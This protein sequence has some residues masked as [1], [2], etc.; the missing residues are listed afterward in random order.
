VQLLEKGGVFRLPGSS[1]QPTNRKDTAMS[2]STATPTS[3]TSTFDF[4]PAE[5]GSKI[6]PPVHAIVELVAAF[7]QRSPT[8]VTTN[9][10]END[11]AERLRILGRVVVEWTFNHVEPEEPAAVP[12]TLLWQDVAYRRK[13]KSR[14]RA[15]CCRFGPIRLWRHRYEAVDT[16]EPSIFPLELALG[17]EAERATPA[18][19]ERV[20]HAAAIHTQ[21]GVLELLARYHGVRWSVKTP[22]KVTASLS[23]GMAEH[24][25]AAQAARGVEALRQASQSAGPHPPT[26]SVGRDGVMVPMRGS[27]AYCEAATGTISVLDRQGRRI[28]TTY[29]GRMPEKEQKTLSL[30]M[31]SLLLAALTL[32]KG[33]LPRLQYVTDGGSHPTSY[34]RQVLRKMRHPVTGARLSWEW[35]IDFFHAS[36]Y[37]T[38]LGEALYGTT[39]KGVAWSAKMRHWLRHKPGGIQRVLYSAAAVHARQAL[40]DARERDYQKAWNYLRK[41]KR[42]MDYA[43][44]KARGLAIGSGVTEAACK[45]VFTQ[46]VKQSGMRWGV[47]GGQVIVDLRI[48]VL[49]R[50]WTETHHAYLASKPKME[51]G[52]LW[53]RDVKKTGK[54]A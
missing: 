28:H 39:R 25:E 37:V 48:L 17:I 10:F 41:R 1:K 21:G 42:R 50:V 51:M 54:A 14:N 20:G 26:L 53:A 16:S 52:T 24:R 44:T 8:P 15:L 36:G 34:F 6:L 23:A 13:P 32:W 43:N 2:Y 31:T 12:T 33:P 7:L 30:Q 35:V 22:R 5:L 46:R 29:L 18:L 9:Q 45:T 47:A 19:A 11:V 3:L 40:S 38:K 49:S 27:Q 4:L